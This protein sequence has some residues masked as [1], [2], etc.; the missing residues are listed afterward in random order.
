MIH[1][2][3]CHIAMCRLLHNYKHNWVDWKAATLYTVNHKKRDILFLTITL[4]NLNRFLQFLYGFNLEEILHATIVKF[5]TSPDLWAHLTW[6]NQKLHFLLWFIKRSSVH[7]TATLSDLTDFNNFCTAETEQN[8][9]NTA[10]IFLNLLLKESV[11]NDV[12]NVLLFA[13][14]VCSCE[15]RHQR[16]EASSVGLCRR[17]RRT[18]WTLLIIAALKITMSKWQHCKFDNWRWLSVLFCC[19]RK[20][21]KNNSVFNWKVL[22]L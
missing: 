19:E 6:R 4:A 20:R 17:W 13:G 21:T 14:P 1:I 12:I 11:A 2:S 18:F 3:P 10:C 7:V 15:P 5:I 16:V 22:F 8:V 9:Q